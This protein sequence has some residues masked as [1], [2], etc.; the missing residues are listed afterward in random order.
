M[1]SGCGCRGRG[2]GSARPSRGPR[3]GP[4]V[5]TLPQTSVIFFALLVGFIVFVTIRGELSSYLWVI[6]LGGSQPAA[7]AAKPVIDLN[8]TRV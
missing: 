1:Q 5:P 2:N 6:G 4:D 7:A 3:R 8:P